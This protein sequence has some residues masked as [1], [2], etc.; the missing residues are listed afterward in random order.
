M[1][2][3][4]EIKRKF[5]EHLL[6]LLKEYGE[7]DGASASLRKFATRSELEYSNVQR[8]SKGQVD[9]ALTT[10]VALAKGLGLKPKDLLDFF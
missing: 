10:I 4:E 8:I 9:L 7:Q 6:K 2:S 5:G 1:D 3:K